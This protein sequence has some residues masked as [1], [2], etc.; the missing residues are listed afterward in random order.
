ME[1]VQVTRHEDEHNR[2]REGDCSGTG[3]LP[4]LIVR[5]CVMQF[6]R[7]VLLSMQKETYAHE[8]VEHGMVF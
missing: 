4:L 2:N 3:V 5:L 6:V 8:A 1:H 7:E